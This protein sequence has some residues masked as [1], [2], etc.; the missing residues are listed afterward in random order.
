MRVLLRDL[1]DLGQE[2]VLEPDRVEAELEQLLVLDEQLVLGCL[3]AR[4]L[5]LV[6]LRAGQAG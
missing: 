5:D 3:L 6:D 1:R 2:V 4:V